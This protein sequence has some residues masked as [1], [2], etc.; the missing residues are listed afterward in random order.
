MFEKLKSHYAAKPE[1]RAGIKMTAVLA[2][3]CS[4]P[5]VLHLMSQ[6]FTSQQVATGMGCLTVTILFVMIYQV[7]LSREEHS[8]AVRD[9]LR[10]H[11]DVY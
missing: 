6:Y 8:Q 4:V 10:K 3:V 7:L 11:N 5:L 2:I 1:L 9:M